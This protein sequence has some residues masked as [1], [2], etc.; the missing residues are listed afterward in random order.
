MKGSFDMKKVLFVIESLGGG[1]AEKVLTTIVK[2]LDKSKYDIT[3]LLVTEVGIYLE[4]VK[5]YCRVVSMLPSYNSLESFIDKLRY[6]LDYKYI[7]SSNPRKVYRKYIKEEYDIEIAFV[8]GYVTRL[9]ANSTNKKSKKIAWVHVDPVE[10]DYADNYYSSLEEQKD[11]YKQFDKIVCVSNSVRYSFIKKMQIKNQVITIY[12]PLDKEYIQSQVNKYHKSRFN[13][14][15]KFIT[16][17]RLEMQ[18]GYD[19]LIDAFSTFPVDSFELNILG[20]GQMRSL[21]EKKIK[22][23]HLENNVHLLGFKRNPYDFMV[24]S[25][26]FICSSRAEGYSLV[27]AEAMILGLPIITTDCSGPNE[28]VEKGKYGILVE[29]SLNGIVSGIDLILNK[30]TDLT[31]YKLLSIKRS[32]MLFDN[33]AINRIDKLISGEII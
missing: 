5:K 3:V 13:K 12:N 25:D 20:E 21:L 8:E 10:R 1:G 23:Y 32:N 6:K 17:G 24:D 9:I 11:S 31:N 14:K 27:I 18:K 22:Q 30:N 2:Y 28:L 33:E 29:N 16:V 7:Y 15:I 26:V 19:R 4:E